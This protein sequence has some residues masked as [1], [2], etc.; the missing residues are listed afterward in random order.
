MMP[1]ELL[2]TSFMPNSKKP[3]FAGR[4]RG[5]YFL[6]NLFTTASL[7]AGFYAI[8]AAMHQQFNMAGI[9]IFVAL[10]FDGLD[11]RVA[12]LI[13]A[14]SAFGAEYDSLSDMVS[15]GVAPALV[16]YN[17]VLHYLGVYGLDKIAWLAAFMYAACVALRL[18]KF[19]VQAELS[20][21]ISKRYFFGLP[22]PPSAA[23]V[24][25]M[26]WLGN[27]YDLAGPHLAIV[28]VFVTV[29]LA[30]LMV[31]NILFRSF[32]DIDMKHNV[33]FPV[34]VLVLLVIIVI[35][36]WPPFALFVIAGVYV[37][38]GPI[39]AGLRWVG[40]ARKRAKRRA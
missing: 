10:I 1:L 39:F 12:R 23:F 38:S 29:A 30:L 9:A 6:P 31:S 7:F 3:A 5:V 35:A 16:L 20:S 2:T 11:G 14:Q 24:A 28:M 26:V 36:L 40:K 18:A 37:C 21:P 33:G 8:V 32:K 19:N 25:S 4:R 27:R 13:N 17:W 22:C 34:M 15:F